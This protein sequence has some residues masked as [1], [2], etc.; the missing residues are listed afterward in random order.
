ML[1]PLTE[2]KSSN[3]IEQALAI[4][5]APGLLK[6]ASRLSPLLAVAAS[7]AYLVHAIF[8]AHALTPISVS[9]V[10]RQTHLHLLAGQIGDIQETFH[11]D[12]LI[13]T[14][15]ISVIV[16]VVVWMAARLTAARFARSRPIGSFGQTPRYQPAMMSSRRVVQQAVAI[17]VI[18]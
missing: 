1:L 13:P 7:Q 9:V 14:M 8:F 12:G 16:F 3:M 18:A 11:W 4:E 6:T 17:G 15:L 10:D 5:P 2:M